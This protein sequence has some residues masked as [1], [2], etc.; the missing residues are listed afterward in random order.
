MVFAL[1]QGRTV[2]VKTHFK[3]FKHEPL[4]SLVERCSHQLL[5]VWRRLCKRKTL[6]DVIILFC[7]IK[8]QQ[9]TVTDLDVV[10]LRHHHS[11]GN[12][13]DDVEQVLASLSDRPKQQKQ[14]QQQLITLSQF[15]EQEQVECNLSA[16]ALVHQVLVVVVQTVEDEQTHVG[17]LELSFLKKVVPQK[18][19]VFI[20]FN[21]QIRVK[22]SALTKHSQRKPCARRANRTEAASTFSCQSTKSHSR[23]SSCSQPETLLESISGSGQSEDK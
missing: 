14:Q 19:N 1:G 4:E 9:T 8:F 20:R 13:V 15:H 18:L 17:V 22:S 10:R 21:F 7:S 23:E 2:N 6:R 12:G 11:V 16:H 5:Q 3:V